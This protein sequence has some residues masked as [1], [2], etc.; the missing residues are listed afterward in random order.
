MIF[1]YH[2]ENLPRRYEDDVMQRNYEY[3]VDSMYSGYDFKTWCQVVQKNSPKEVTKE[4]C[5]KIWQ[6]AW[7]DIT[8]DIIS[9]KKGS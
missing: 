8:D 3:A 4:E 1:F 9:Q 7:R 2:Y 5:E 6:Q